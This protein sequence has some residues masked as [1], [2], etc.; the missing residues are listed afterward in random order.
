MSKPLPSTDK[1]YVGGRRVMLVSAAVF[2]LSRA[3][4]YLPST[5]N[6]ELTPAIYLLSGAVGI[7]VWVAAWSLVVLLCVTDLFRVTSRI[8]IASLVGM[9]IL[10]GSAYMISYI[11]TVINVGWG[12]REWFT[13]VT[14]AGPAG[15]IYGL[16]KKVGALKQK[17]DAGE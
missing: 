14:Y 7:Y 12:S 6:S 8:G 10:W 9:L 2:A 11:G 5:S 16:L 17:E 13:F 1:R 15:V 4:Y 3:L